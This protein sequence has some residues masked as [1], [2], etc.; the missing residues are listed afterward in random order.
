M[1]HIDAERA[2][3]T[4][5]EASNQ[6]SEDALSQALEQLQVLVEDQSQIDNLDNRGLPSHLVS[7]STCFR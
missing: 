2:I 3:A 4:L 1:S 5:Q 6:G 7:V